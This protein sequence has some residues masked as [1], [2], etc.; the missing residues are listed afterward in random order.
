MKMNEAGMYNLRPMETVIHLPGLAR[1]LTIVHITDSHLTEADDREAEDVL[2]M[3]A[4]RTAIFSQQEHGFGRSTVELFN[5]H[6]RTSN[7]WGADCTVFTGDIIDFPSRANLE[8]I[9]QSFAG[10]QSQLLYTM[11]NHDWCYPHRSFDDELRVQMYDRFRR[12]SAHVPGCELLELNGVT[13]IAVDNSNYQVTPEQYNRIREQAAKGPCLLFM[14]IP[15]YLP[16]L[17]QAV[18]DVWGSPIMMGAE[19]WKDDAARHSWGVRQT[20]AS[21][22]ALCQWLSN[23]AGSE[24]VLGI[25]CGHV[26]FAHTDPFREGRFQYVTEPGFTGG[27]RIIRLQG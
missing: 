24:Q 5:E 2:A 15:L 26:H 3:A 11:G 21:T 18:V 14:H 25:F 13:L 10:L 4:E 9:E 22:A 17:E 12:W 23:G 6:I 7:L 19:S 27:C 20:D 8:L 1:D 16:T